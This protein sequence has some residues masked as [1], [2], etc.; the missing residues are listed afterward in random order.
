MEKWHGELAVWL[1]GDGWKPNIIQEEGKVRYY[2]GNVLVQSRR[3]YIVWQDCQ[4]SPTKSRGKFYI[5]EDGKAPKGFTQILFC[6]GVYPNVLF[7]MI[8][9]GLLS[10]NTADVQGQTG[11]CCWMAVQC[12]AG[13]LAAPLALT[14]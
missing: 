9:N 4:E 8:G 1:R 6:E 5:G 3:S 11:L 13:C 14:H 12:T 2:P 7:P 10:L